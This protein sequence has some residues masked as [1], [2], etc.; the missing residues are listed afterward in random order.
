MKRR[1]IF[2][3][4]CG[5][6]VFIITMAMACPNQKIQEMLP[7]GDPVSTATAASGVSVTK[8]SIE[9]DGT[10][11]PDG[12]RPVVVQF[13]IESD[14]VIKSLRI[15]YKNSLKNSFNFAVE[16]TRDGSFKDAMP[17]NLTVNKGVDFCCAE[18]EPAK[19]SEIRIWFPEKCVFEGVSF[20]KTSLEPQACAAKP[21][22]TGCLW[23]AF[24]TVTAF[25]AVFFIDKRFRLSEKITSYLKKKSVRITMLVLGVGISVILGM[26]TEIVFRLVL[27]A[28]SLGNGFNRASCASFCAVYVCIFALIFERK[29]LAKKPEKALLIFVLTAGTLTIL[30]QPMGHN[31]WDLDTHYTLALE[32]SYIDTAYYSEADLDIKSNKVVASVKTLE[33]SE[34]AKQI[35]N[36]ADKIA[37]MRTGIRRKVT[38]LPSGMFIAV[39]RMFGADFYTKYV[40]GEFANLLLYATVCYFAVKKL[41]SGKMI[42]SVI[43]LFPTN[44]FIASNYS[45]D[46]WVTAFMLLGTCYFV[47]ECEQPEKPVTVYETVVMCGAFAL[48]S[49]PKQ[50]YILLMALPFF[51]RKNWKTKRAKK[52]YYLILIA[53]FAAVFLMLLIRSFGAVSATSTGDTRGGDVNPSEQLSFILTSPFKYAGILLKFLWGYL[54][55]AGMPDY[56]ALF[57]YFGLGKTAI[58]FQLMLLFTMLTGKNGEKRSCPWLTRILAILM[59]IGISAFIATALYIDFTPLKSNVIEG[60]QPRYIIPLLPPVALTLFG[61]GIRVFKNKAVYNGIVLTVLC[62][63]C[64]FDI[65]GKAAIL[66]M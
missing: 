6:T 15:K 58:I 3:A 4:I 14:S 1:I 20:Y 61:S 44:I 31:C 39:A 49:L 13:K 25:T 43:V 50:I 62:A 8:G 66:T 2:S 53:F 26:I 42:A 48:G 30:A 27:G 63:A 55:P 38:H 57:A 35:L 59:Y 11:K 29:G 40:C 52:N 32:N 65:I 18:L 47:S 24:W 41:K 60:C 9:S 54:L 36:D 5:I 34:E 28:D 17:V 16:L 19:Y 22:V 7:V 51:I 10:V 21:T 37:I 23:V 33:K 56:I 46:H 45:Y 64:L 12:T